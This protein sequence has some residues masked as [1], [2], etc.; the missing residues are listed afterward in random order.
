MLF[1]FYSS[2]FHIDTSL[3]NVIQV[4]SITHSP[5]RHKVVSSN[6]EGQTKSNN[7]EV[8]KFDRCAGEANTTVVPQSNNKTVR[9]S[10]CPS[11]YP[12]FFKRG[13]RVNFFPKSHIR[14]RVGEEYL[15][16]PIGGRRGPDPCSPQMHTWCQ[17]LCLHNVILPQIL[18]TGGCEK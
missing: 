17:L 8:R 5:D 10:R 6:F 14:I 18:K 15:G 7:L 16:D 2:R 13:A 12:R 11:A 4:N 3:P 9:L 1:P